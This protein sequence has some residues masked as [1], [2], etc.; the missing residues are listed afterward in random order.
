MSAVRD[1]R[2]NL[3]SIPDDPRTHEES[4]ADEQEDGEEDEAEEDKNE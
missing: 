4:Q 2:F 3:D 1:F